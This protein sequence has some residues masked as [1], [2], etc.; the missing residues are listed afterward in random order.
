MNSN[1][2]SFISTA[3]SNS[4]VVFGKY[5]NDKDKFKQF[6]HDILRDRCK[7]KK[8]DMHKYLDNNHMIEF[9]KVFTHPTVDPINNY[10]FYEC[11]GDASLNTSVVY[12]FHY[13]FPQ[14]RKAKNGVAFLSKLK[15][16]GISKKQ[17]SEYSKKLHF[18]DFIL[19]DHNKYT[20][21]FKRFE[22]D[23]KKKKMLKL[24]S[25]NRPSKIL[26]DVFE[27]FCGC[28]SLMIDE[29][30]CKQT[31]GYT[32]VYNIL[33]SVVDKNSISLDPYVL[34]DPV[35]LLKELFDIRKASIT[36]RDD[37]YRIEKSTTP[38]PQHYGEFKFSATSYVKINNNIEEKVATVLSDDDGEVAQ[39]VAKETLLFLDKKYNI[40]QSRHELEI[41]QQIT[42]QPINIEHKK[43]L[44]KKELEKKQ[45]DKKKQTDENKK[46][47]K[48]ELDKVLY[49]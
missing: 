39:K 43:Q 31:A 12:Y 40:R 19:Y 45:E 24:H 14:L 47:L 11:L 18:H 29:M 16:E 46:I 1:A 7:I 42:Q 36:N 8:E 6:I 4:K 13:H 5:A 27:A 15:I 17:F 28:V 22:D 34:W 20:S 33:C 41:S 23:K 3:T 10:D 2:P 30:Y 21:E 32:A 25:D 9:Q 35:T 49:I 48:K 38:D 37:S 44:L 26:T